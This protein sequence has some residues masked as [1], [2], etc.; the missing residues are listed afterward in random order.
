MKQI[1]NK[2]IVTIL[3][4]YIFWILI[5]PLIFAGILPEVCKKISQNTNYIVEIKQPRLILTPLPTALFKTKNIEVKSKT[6]EDFIKIENFE[7]SLRLLPLLSGRININKVSADSVEINSVLNKKL[8]LDKK[9]FANLNKTKIRCKEINVKQITI[10]IKQPDVKEPVIYLAH[11]LY[12][13][14][15][16]KALQCKLHSELNIKNSI[17]ETNINLYLPKNNN[18]NKSIID[19]KFDNFYLEP[20]CDYLRQYLPYDLTN[21]K[22]I[23][24]VRVDKKNIIATLRDCAILM[25]DDAKSIIFPDKLDII[26]KFNV[27]SKLINFENIDIKS[28]NINTTI[29]GTISNYMDRSMTMLDLNVCL[30]K[31]RVEDIVAAMPPLVVEELNVYKLKKYKFYGDVIGNFSIKGDIYEPDI[32]GEV[33]INNGILIKPIKNAGKATIKLIF[34]GKYLNYDVDVPAGG[35][36]RVWI[37]GSV[38]LYNVKYANMRVWS[39]S[40]VDLQTAE[41]KVLPIHEILNFIIG[42]VPIMNIK[43]DGNIDITIKGNRKNPHVWGVLNF[44]NVKTF[45][46]EIPDMVLTNATA[47]LKFNDQNALFET[48]QGL[49]NNVPISIK[50]TCNLFGNFDFDIK[51]N[52][53]EIEYLYHAIETS[54]ML[55]DIRKMLPKLDI[56]KGKL[57]LDMKVY[58]SIIDVKDIQFNKN[59]FSKGEIELL[60]NTFGL[61]GTQI[62]STKG[63]INFEGTGANVDINALIGDSQ[64]NAKANVKNNLA[65]VSVSIPHLNINNILPAANDIK[66][67]FGNIYANVDAKYKGKLDNI[68]YDK[69]D[70]NA[71]IL[72]T[73][74]Q[75]K[76]KISGGTVSLSGNKLKVTN[77]KGSLAESQ[78]N[79]N[80]NIS[81]DNISHA[82]HVNGL[83]QLKSFDPSILNLLSSYSFIPDEFK[84]IEFKEGIID[85]DFKIT[86][87]NINAYTDL[88][89]LTFI[90]KPLSLPIKI[91]NGNF[92]IKN[93]DLNL[94]KIN[95]LADNMPVLLDGVISNIFDKQNFDIYINSKPKQDFIDKYINKNQ[96]YPVKI[97]GDIVYSLRAKGIKDNFDLKADVNM[98]PD[99]TIYHLGATVGDVENAISLTLDT[100]VIKQNILKIKEFSYDKIISSL[101]SRSTRLNMLKAKGGIEIYNDDLVFHNLHIKTQNPTDARIFNIIFRKPNIKQGQFTSDLKFNG[102]LSA[103]KLLGDF[104]IFE[105]NIPF[106]DTTMK[107]ITFKFKDKTIDLSSKGEILGNDITIQ[108]TLKNKLTPPYYVE[109]ADLYTKIFDL[110]DIIEKLKLSQVDNY[111]TFESFEGADLTS[112]IIKDMNLNADNIYLRNIIA[113]DFNANVS[114]DEKKILDVN[115]FEFSIAD[116]ILSGKFKYNMQN[117]DTYLDLRAKDINANDLTVALFDLDNQIYGDLTGEIKLSCNGVDFEN[118][119]KTLNGNSK[120]NVSDGRMPKL[121]SLEYLL[122][123]GNLL[124]GG[125]TGV[126]INSIIDIITPLKT[127]NFSNINGQI[128]IKEGEADKIEIST[129]GNDL[130]LFI[131]GKYNFSTSN[132]KMEVFGLLSKKISTMFGPIGNLSL[133]TLFNAIPGVDLSKDNKIIEQINKIPGIEL[134]SKAYRK[135]LAEIEGNINGDDYV[136]S[137]RWIN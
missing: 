113:K 13:K 100:K 123:A 43:G 104:H 29:A 101:S 53:Q 14:L 19:I 94:V 79:F 8:Q 129:R 128:N 31:S 77:L 35:S 82:P 58:G 84:N 103:P 109:K 88:G 57:N 80:I 9:F 136:T 32:N 67:D 44:N 112:I 2:Y 96:I 27:T 60:D 121:G 125:I 85:T 38:E 23:I 11:D 87:N 134:S 126:S 64:L 124:K 105:T 74:P 75:N 111:T 90:Y 47:V 65:D 62:N 107:N 51:S 25:K 7:T 36:E 24:N 49:V 70:F 50:G 39:T 54:T 120:F 10:N 115:N 26:S 42:P 72:G 118:C 17:S 98:A 131:T 89:G 21:I 68:E 117:N 78:S 56:C 20:L 18:V 63:K 81:A 95:L 48:K 52:S 114:A 33:Y 34:K 137:F 69:V 41:E 6:S 110:N 55:D 15:T 106:L 37:K 40:K 93:N 73:S 122:K 116:G 3:I 119:M 16:T 102:K 76:L 45:F 1:F 30:N 97:K 5:L 83:I 86:N 28:G 61:Q 99:S 4:F 135:F 92:L 127:G 130:N 46:N 22:G 59:L 66:S 71:I 133:N 12:Y 108:A 132:A 91:V